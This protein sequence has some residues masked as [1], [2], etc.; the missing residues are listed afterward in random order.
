MKLVINYSQLKSV[1][2]VKGRFGVHQV[3]PDHSEDVSFY[4]IKKWIR[5]DF[6]ELQ[7]KI[8]KLFKTF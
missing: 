8:K 1:C 2:V 3:V 7:E 5:N 6:S 4:T